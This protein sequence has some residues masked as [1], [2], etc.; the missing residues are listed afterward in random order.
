MHYFQKYGQEARFISLVFDAQQI[1]QLL[2]FSSTRIHYLSGRLKLFLNIVLAMN[3]TILLTNEHFFS[4]EIQTRRL[5]NHSNIQGII[6][7]VT[8]SVDEAVVLGDMMG[9]LS[10]KFVGTRKEYVNLLRS[11]DHYIMTSKTRL[12]TQESGELYFDDEIGEDSKIGITK[13]FH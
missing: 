10:T 4:L 7:F 5:Y 12:N 13:V 11:S 2:Y 9:T 3:P 1:V 8:Y 6:L